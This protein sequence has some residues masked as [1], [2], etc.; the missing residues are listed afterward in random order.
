MVW[1]CVV[2]RGMPAAGAV[3]VAV[4]VL[5]MVDGVDELVIVDVVDVGAAHGIAPAPVEFISVNE[6]NKVHPSK[7]TSSFARRP[8]H[9]PLHATSG[10]SDHNSSTRY[11]LSSGFPFLHHSPF[12]YVV[13]KI[14]PLN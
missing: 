10:H 6:Q 7:S 8:Y 2:A 3:R 14:K 12:I 4:D 5:V 11:A 1:G 9:V 13:S